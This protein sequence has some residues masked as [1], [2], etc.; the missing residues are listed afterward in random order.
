MYKTFVV[1]AALAVGGNAFAQRD[2]MEASADA[3]AASMAPGAKRVMDYFKGADKKTDYSILLEAGKCY[4][5]TAA[6][7]PGVKKIALYLWAPGAGVFTPRLT[8]AK[9]TNGTVT[10]AHCPSQSGMHKFQAKLEGSG[11]YTVGLY[12]KEA[13]QQAAAPAP[14]PAPVAVEKTP[15]LGP[16]CDKTA[17]GAA[18]G[19]KRQGEFFD[20][21][22]GSIGHKDR[23]DYSIA[24]DGG[25]C[26]WIV[27]C[28]EPGEVKALSLY[29]WG[30]NNK[31]ITEAKPDSPNVMVGHCA[32]MTGMYKVQSVVAGGS[33]HYKVGIYVK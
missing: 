12:A 6:V 18:P 20:G 10:M 3:Q 11:M 23:A 33:G 22:G 9:S 2:P 5:W 30:P 15:D 16:L 29:L 25:K 1:V 26:Y 24:M 8:D 17:S 4:W 7:T 31:R 32:Q 14:A 21:K 19:A 27:G 13:P 28:G